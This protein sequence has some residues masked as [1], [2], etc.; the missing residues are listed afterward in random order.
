[1]IHINEGLIRDA[2]AEGVEAARVEL[3]LSEWR[4]LDYDIAEAA[5]TQAVAAL[6]AKVGRVRE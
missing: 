1:M 2:I 4:P 3:G 6:V 5:A